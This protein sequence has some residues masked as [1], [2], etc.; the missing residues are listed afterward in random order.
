[1]RSTR[2]RVELF[3]FSNFQTFYE[4]DKCVIFARAVVHKCAVGYQ[5]Q[6]NANANANLEVFQDWFLKFVVFFKTSNDG[7][8][9]GCGLGCWNKCAIFRADLYSIM[10]RSYKTCKGSF[11]DINY[12]NVH[13]KHGNLC[14]DILVEY[15]Y[16]KTGLM[17]GNTILGKGFKQSIVWHLREIKEIKRS[18]NL[19][20][21]LFTFVFQNK[22]CMLCISTSFGVHLEGHPGE[23]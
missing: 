16:I 10:T 21:F 3:F 12:A 20:I 9:C 17:G 8:G 13:Q 18:K 7:L 1:L 11:H 2:E 14:L 19:I 22:L 6:A 4:P 5:S 15:F 23:G